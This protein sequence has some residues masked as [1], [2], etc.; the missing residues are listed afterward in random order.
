MDRPD[1]P[2]ASTDDQAF[3]KTGPLKSGV[4]IRNDSQ[5]ALKLCECY[6]IVLKNALTQF[7]E[8][9]TFK[10]VHVGSLSQN[11]TVSDTTEMASNSCGLN[12]WIKL[13]G[14]PNFTFKIS[15]TNEIITLWPFKGLFWGEDAH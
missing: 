11:F 2:K 14:S 15:G 10:I 4:K 7:I 1:K 12:D 6:I 5:S 13:C 8:S 9:S 3:N